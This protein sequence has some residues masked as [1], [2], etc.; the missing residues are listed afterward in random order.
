MSAKTKRAL[1]KKRYLDNKDASQ[2]Y[3][4]EYRESNRNAIRESQKQYSEQNKDAKKLSV[5]QHYEQN[6][7][8]KKLIVQQH[9]EKNKDAKILCVLQRYEENKDAIKLSVRQQYQHNKQAKQLTVRQ[10]YQHNKQAKQ[11]SVRQ[12]YEQNKQAKQLSVRQHH[13]HNKQAKQLNVK[14]YYERN[15]DAKLVMRKLHYQQNKECTKIYCK[16]YYT[17]NRDILACKAKFLYSSNREF[18]KVALKRARKYYARNRTSI[19]ASKR[20]R[21]NLAEPKPCIQQQYVL[22]AKKALLHNK[23]VMKEVI[24]YFKSQQEGAFEKMNKR[25]RTAAIAQVAAH[26]LIAK[27]LQ[28]RKQYVGLLLKTVKHV[29]GLHIKGQCDFGEGLH[30]VCSEPYYYKSIYYFEHKRSVF[31]VD[32]Y[33]KCCQDIEVHDDSTDKVWKCS[34]KCKPLTECE[35]NTILVFKSDFD[36]PMCELLQSLCMVC[37]SEDW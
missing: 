2:L 36:A 27:A 16:N 13:Q 17:R 34:S 11:L 28:I 31:V 22:A 37:V 9:Y 26:R 19:C 12:H 23:K 30:S 1:R 3:M 10:H 32:S 7:D 24:N 35:V 29:C 15:K 8:A 20:R 14:Q 33:G 5:Q 6:K 18:A 21:Y 4:K 25:S